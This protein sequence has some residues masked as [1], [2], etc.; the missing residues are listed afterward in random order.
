MVTEFFD[1]GECGIRT[2]VPLRTTAFRVRRVTTT[3]L[4][5]HMKTTNNENS[6]QSER[7]TYNN[8]HP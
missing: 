7:I 3:S 5:L 6:I 8:T 2:H 4:T 1:N